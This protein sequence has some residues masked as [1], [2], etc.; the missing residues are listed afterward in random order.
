MFKRHRPAPPL[1]INALVQ[2]PPPETTVAEIRAQVGRLLERRRA[3]RDEISRR[4][5][6]LEDS[7]RDLQQEAESLDAEIAHLARL[8]EML[9]PDFD[10]PTPEPPPD[11]PAAPARADVPKVDEDPAPDA[12]GG[13]PDADPDDSDD[14]AAAPEPPAGTAPARP[15]PPRNRNRKHPPRK[16]QDRNAAALAKRDLCERAY[17]WIVE[18]PGQSGIAIARGIGLGD[19]QTAAAKISSI[20]REL[21]ADKVES[22]PAGKGKAWYPRAGSRSNGIETPPAPPSQPPGKLS[23]RQRKVYDAVVGGRGNPAK[24]PSEVAHLTNL[25]LVQVGPELEALTAQGYLQRGR[26]DAGPA[27]F[28]PGRRKP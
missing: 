27:V 10:T 8:A 1:A 15:R 17:R 23:D 3:G 20:L 25:A 28:A 19:N 26:P 14:E 12:D 5:Q 6:D 21:Q 16:A 13:A 24:T 9:D 2:G 11:P 7:G 18:N 4:L 22:K